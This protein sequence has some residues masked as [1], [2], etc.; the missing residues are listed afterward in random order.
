MFEVGETQQTLQ[1]AIETA[2]VVEVDEIALAATTFVV[3]EA[4][5]LDVGDHESDHG[6]PETRSFGG[7]C[8]PQQARGN[9]EIDVGVRNLPIQSGAGACLGPVAVARRARIDADRE[10]VADQRLE[11]TQE[12]GRRQQSSCTWPV[13]DDGD[14]YVAC[15]RNRGNTQKSQE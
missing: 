14:G 2:V 7:R 13:V 10:L 3:R 1:L 11:F 5:Q 4:L 8:R 6:F 12:G 15:L 9:D